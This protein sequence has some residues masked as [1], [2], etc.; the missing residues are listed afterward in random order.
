MEVI[1]SIG[2]RIKLARKMKRFSQGPLPH[3]ALVRKNCYFKI[4]TGSGQRGE[5]SKKLFA[6]RG[7]TIFIIV[8][9]NE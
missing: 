9:C 2:E 7:I 6:T 5:N 8:H 1:M 3:R 4:H